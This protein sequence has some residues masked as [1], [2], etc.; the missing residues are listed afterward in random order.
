MTQ[1]W[2]LLAT[3]PGKLDQVTDSSRRKPQEKG[4]R[5]CCNTA[6][7]GAQRL[8]EQFSAL[9]SLEAQWTVGQPMH[10]RREPLASVSGQEH[11]TRRQGRN[12]QPASAC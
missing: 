1:T 6:P 11:N 2:R 7:L 3:C 9:T 12:E 8:S 5:I 4:S 10:R